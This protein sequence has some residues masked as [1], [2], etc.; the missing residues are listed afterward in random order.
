MNESDHKPRRGLNFL[1]SVLG[2]LVVLVVGAVLIQTKV[3]DTGDTTTKVVTDS[4][5][6]VS[7]AGTKASKNTSATSGR[8]V[9]EIYKDEGQGVVFVKSEGVKSESSSSSPFGQP[10]GQGSTAT[11]SGFVVSKDGYI[12]TNAHVVEG[13]KKVS[14]SFKEDTS[15]FVDAQV[16][17]RDVSSDL[18][19]LKVDPSKVKN[20][21]TLP[22]GNSKN[23]TVGD[24]VIAIGNPFGFTRTVT[25]GIVSAVQRTIEAPNNFSIADVIQTDAAINPGNSGGPL[26]DAGGNV[27]GINAQIATGGG[28]SSSSGGSVGIGFAIPINTLK[29]LLP[30]LKKGGEIQRGF[31]GVSSTS[32]TSDV[33]KQLKLGVKS[34]ALIQQV[35][36]GGPAATAGLRAGKNPTSSGLVAGSDV[37]VKADGK[38]I[39]SS[40]QLVTVISAKKPGD[41]VEI[42]YYRGDKR[43]TT[44]VT[45]KKRPTTAQ[46]Q[47]PGKGGGGL[48]P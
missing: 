31:L 40:N 12:V 27:I 43:K 37:I 33:A 30:Q 22:L 44:Q 7:D 46:S 20:I 42:Q 17:G 14:V 15:N 34:G 19:V 21:R 5:R 24:P 35:T 28:S 45:L 48:T 16:K 13:A 32:V 9:A 18:A 26:L 29:K 38:D 25:T 10:D 3:I 41:K 2:G 36:P 4:T 6:P 11:G 39:K 8:T 47:R 23:A 1:S